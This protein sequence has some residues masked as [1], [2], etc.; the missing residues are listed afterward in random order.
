MVENAELSCTRLWQNGN[1]HLATV[2]FGRTDMDEVYRYVLHFRCC[3]AFDKLIPSPD[4]LLFHPAPVYAGLAIYL[5]WEDHGS[6]DLWHHK[7]L[8]K[9]T[10]L[11]RHIELRR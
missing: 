2:L 7:E 5:T 11:L 10:G 9:C 6:P 8:L 1:R 3:Y 4:R